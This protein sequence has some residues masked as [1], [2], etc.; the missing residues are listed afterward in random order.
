M[1]DITTM[2]TDDN[3][4]RIFEGIP[5]IREPLTIIVHTKGSEEEGGKANRS[6]LWL[7]YD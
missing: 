7:Y 4:T 6:S 5:Q 2:C 1:N 3:C